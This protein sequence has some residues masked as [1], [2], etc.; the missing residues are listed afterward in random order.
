MLNYIN[1]SACKKAILNLAQKRAHKF[2]R[3]GTDV[4]EH[5]DIVLLNAM[6]SIVESHPSMG[7]TIMMGSKKRST[8]TDDLKLDD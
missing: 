3:V 7:K 6:K 4:F 2:T 1:K 8:D 5:L